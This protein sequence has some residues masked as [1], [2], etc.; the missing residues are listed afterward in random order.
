MKGSTK[1]PF[2]DRLCYGELLVLPFRTRAALVQ[3]IHRGQ[4]VEPEH[5]TLAGTYA[6]KRLRLY[7]TIAIA[8]AVLFLLDVVDA[9]IRGTAGIPVALGA[10]GAACVAVGN[11]LVAWR[12]CRFIR[13]N[14]VDDAASPAQG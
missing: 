12:L 3:R 5:R 9:A 1:A 13:A 6:R 2:F 11:G 4:A 14:E 8:A 7:S 10:C